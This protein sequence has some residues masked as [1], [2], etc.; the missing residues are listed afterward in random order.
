MRVIAWMV[1]SNIVS[2]SMS[3]KKNL[4]TFVYKDIVLHNIL[5]L[6]SLSVFN[7]AIFTF[8]S[9]DICVHND[10]VLNALSKLCTRPQC[11]LC[12][13]CPRTR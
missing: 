11:Y 4:L 8:T 12:Q 9:V 5:H 2:S 10:C 1:K 6:I 7:M 13:N 3:F